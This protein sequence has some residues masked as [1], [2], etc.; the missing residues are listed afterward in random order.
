MT[1]ENFERLKESI[2]EAG[3]VMRGER[4]AT[5]ESVHEIQLPREMAVTT[6]AFASKQT[7]RNCLSRA[8]F[9][10]LPCTKMTWRERLMK[11]EKLLSTWQASLSKSTNEYFIHS[12][13]LGWR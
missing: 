7:V 1:P 5:R 13:R 12:R 10:K 2:V 9:T 3:Q 11:L 4:A 8:K 6:L